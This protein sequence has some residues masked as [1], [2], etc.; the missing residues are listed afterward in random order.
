MRRAGKPCLGHTSYI[1]FGPMWNAIRSTIT[2]AVQIPSR[3]YIYLLG[4]FRNA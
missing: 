3:I 2:L 1:I 4:A